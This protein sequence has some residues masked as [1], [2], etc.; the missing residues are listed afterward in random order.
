MREG[1]VTGPSHGR[2]CGFGQGT[3]AQQ[4]TLPSLNMRK[5]K[6]VIN[7]NSFQLSGSMAGVEGRG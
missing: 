3:A 6:K 4:G 5:I 2:T 7:V 1:L